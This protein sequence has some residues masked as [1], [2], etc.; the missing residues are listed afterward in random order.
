MRH[1][2]DGLLMEWLDGEL[3]PSA[4]QELSEHIATCPACDARAVELR[5]TLAEADALVGVLDEPASRAA[6]ATERLAISPQDRGSPVVLLPYHDMLRWKRTA[7]RRNMGI[8]A[9]LIVAA[10]AGW[11]ALRPNSLGRS[12]PQE[13]A[14]ANLPQA[15][16]AP[17]RPASEVASAA[18][19]DSAPAGS[20]TLADAPV[21]SATVASQ[22]QAEPRA[23]AGAE[24]H[25]DRNA[26]AAAPA[27][28]PATAKPPAFAQAEVTQVNPRQQAAG[29]SRAEAFQPEIANA[30]PQPVSTLKA[31]EERTPLAALPDSQI[32]T[33]IG[34][35]EAR[36]E[37]GGNLHV[38]DGL[39]PEMVGLVPGRLVPGA[40]PTRPVV[41]VVYLNDAGGSFFLDQQRVAAGTRD[42]RQNLPQDPTGWRQGNVQLRLHGALPDDSLRGLA[43]R[44]K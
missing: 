22:E 10:G 7:W 39:R 33:R 34:L 14:T 6:D 9:S 8:A 13:T 32:S 18:V 5:A 1:P 23:N 37:L 25:V 17:S 15:V 20:G 40:D 26:D 31:A 36:R 28:V 24:S 21:E 19:G 4:A 11:L 3:A 41:R 42:E 35:D 44:V 38:I 12:G 43:R 27:P 2:D 30:A 16:E 29:R